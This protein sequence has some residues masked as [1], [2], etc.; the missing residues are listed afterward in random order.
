MAVELCESLRDLVFNVLAFYSPDTMSQ[1]CLLEIKVGDLLPSPTAHYQV[2]KVLGQGI[3]GVV[4]QCR[5]VTTYETVALKMIKSKEDIEFAMEEEVILQTLKK[6]HS[7]RFN[8]ARFNESFTYQ[9]HYCL[10]FEHLDVDLQS[11][12]QFFLGQQLQLR[13]IR[14]IL[15]QVG[16]LNSSSYT[17]L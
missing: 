6:L 11:F 1:N 17:A 2:Q 4:I 15:Q 8:I 9:G 12:K 3:Y 10:V 7:D 5:N 13:Q 14:P 16:F